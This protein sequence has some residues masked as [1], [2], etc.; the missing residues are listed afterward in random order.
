MEIY[1]NMLKEKEREQNEINQEKEKELYRQ[2]LLEQQNQNQ[3]G[4]QD[5]NSNKINESQNQNQECQDIKE[6]TIPKNE[7]NNKD[8]KPINSF[9]DYYKQKNMNIPEAQ[10]E[11]KNYSPQQNLIENKYEGDIYPYEQYP[12]KENQNIYPK[13]QEPLSEEQAYMIYQQQQQ[14]RQ[15]LERI[16]LEKERARQILQR[17]QEENIN[18]QQIQNQNDYYPQSYNN[19]SNNYPYY[20]QN[21]QESAKMSEFNSAKMEYLAQFLDSQINAK[22][23][24]ENKNKKMD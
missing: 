6:N 24:R 4:Q 8:N 3:L 5:I 17:Q 11:I 20:N 13:S 19:N 14:D 9:E 1:Q 7:I 21:Y 10:P 15:E 22:N 2:Y 12:P 18:Q 16:E 23:M